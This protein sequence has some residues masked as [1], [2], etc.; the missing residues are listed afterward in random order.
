MLV[1]LAVVVVVVLVVL[2]AVAV[3]VVDCLG[4]LIASATP[5]SSSQPNIKAS[6]PFAS[7]H[8]FSPIKCT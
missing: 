3:V 8:G 4:A 5:S 6:V 7:P 2:A 1:L